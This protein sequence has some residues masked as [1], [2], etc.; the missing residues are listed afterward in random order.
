MMTS[1][2]HIDP[3]TRR[4]GFI[5]TVSGRRFW[6]LDPRAA[7]VDL[8]DIATALSNLCRWGGHLDR[9]YSVA[10][11]SVLVALSLPHS[12]RPQ[13]LLH[14]AAEAYCVDV[15]APIKVYLINYEVIEARLAA[16]IGDR[17]GVELCSLDPQVE[18]ADIRA[19][20]TEQRDLRPTRHSIK[21]IQPWMARI[22]PWTVEESREN[23]L[24]LARKLG[25]K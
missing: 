13:G 21:S 16:A 7:D 10:Q 8:G 22:V 18:A 3:S 5:T 4:G 2:D 24:G 14:D 20:V 15:P 12:L 17:F 9:H 11:H 19:R 6:P 1:A 23:F 25:V